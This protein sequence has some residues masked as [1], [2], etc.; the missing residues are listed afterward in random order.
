[1]GVGR[2]VFR[3]VGGAWGGRPEPERREP[4]KRVLG[5]P[6]DLLHIVGCPV[7]VVVVVG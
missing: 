1:M 6:G 7:V 5:D 2:P 3:G 4:L